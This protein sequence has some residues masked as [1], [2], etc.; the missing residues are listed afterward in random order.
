MKRSFLFSLF[1]L[2]AMLS[3]S[4]MSKLKNQQWEEND[5]PE[6]SDWFLNQRIYPEGKINYTYY[7]EA[8]DVAK[9]MN[10]AARFAEGSTALPNWVFAGPT[11]I[12]GRVTCI[13][14]HSSSQ[15][16][17]YVGSASGGVF[18]STNQG[19][20]WNPIFDANPS[21]SIGDIAI[22]PS[23][24]NILFVGTGEPNNG[25]GS[26]TYDGQGIFKS[27]DAGVTWTSVG[28]A[29]TRNT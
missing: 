21:L 26:V 23:N 24:A 4:P 1:A 7:N 5:K 13:N 28:L 2:C 14:M 11:N 22:A 8:L 3:F 27:I 12:G 9:N 16:I 10:T 29:N 20:S 18:K 6:V 19:T 17:I 15:Q 25:R